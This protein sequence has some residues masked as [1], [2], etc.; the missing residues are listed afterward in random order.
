MANDEKLL[1][2]I[3][4]GTLGLIPLESIKDMGERVDKY[5]VKWR[6][7]REHGHADTITFNRYKRDTYILDADCPRFKCQRGIRK[8]LPLSFTLYELKPARLYHF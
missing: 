3:P 8:D 1:Q 7:K 6:A 2:T 5:L 4:N